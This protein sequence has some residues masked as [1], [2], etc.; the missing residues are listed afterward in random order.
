MNN[1]G[2]TLVELL[3][4]I[5]VLAIVISVAFFSV[6]KIREDELK[7]I[8]EVKIGQIEQAAILY[9]Q[10]NP[11]ILSESCVVDDVYYDN[12]C[13]VLTVRELINAGGN[14]FE[15]GTT[16]WSD[17]VLLNRVGPKGEAGTGDSISSIKVEFGLSSSRTSYSDVT[18][19]S[20]TV[21]ET[22]TSKRYIWVRTTYSGTSG[23]IDTTYSLYTAGREIVS[24]TNYYLGST[25]SSGITNTMSGWSTTIVTP[26]ASLPYVWNYE[27]ITYNDGTTQK[28]A[29]HIIAM[30]GKDGKDGQRGQLVYPAGTYSNTTRYTTD[31]NKAPYVLDPS[32]GNYYVLNAQMTWLGTQQNNRTPAQDYAANKGKYWMRFEGFDAIY[33]KIGIINNGLIGSAVFNGDYM[34]SQYGYNASGNLTTSYQNFSTG[35]FTTSYTSGYSFFPAYAVNLKTGGIYTFGPQQISTYRSQVPIIYKKIM[36]GYEVTGAL[37]SNSSTY[38]SCTYPVEK[39]IKNGTYEVHTI[40][41]GKKYYTYNIESSSIDVYGVALGGG[42]SELLVNAGNS[43]LEVFPWSPFVVWGGTYETPSLTVLS[44]RGEMFKIISNGTKYNTVSD[45]LTHLGANV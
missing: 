1:K 23:V 19:W 38:N 7:R 40:A 31:V 26:T 33:A 8:V 36:P 2:F 41:N 21:P 12:Y 44:F 28:S 32:D 37:Y 14:Y 18:S 4:V 15:S 13:K 43:T 9:A 39:V 3:G 42:N 6:N 27:L 30:A 10:D 20:T 16:R 25:S 5:V 34:F 24:I 11:S 45:W 29:A 35:V 22:T 17:P